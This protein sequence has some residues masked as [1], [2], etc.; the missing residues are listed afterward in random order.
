MK[1]LAALLV[2]LSAPAFSNTAK[3]IDS[4]K[5]EIIRV[6]KANMTN[7]SNLAEV[8]MELDSL[9]QQLVAISPQVTEEHI[10][11]YSPGSWQQI[12][13]DETN[14]DPP[15]MPRRDLAQIYQ[16]V[17]PMGWGY[18]F[19]V[20]K[21]D[22]TRSATFALAVVASVNGNQ[23]TTEITK[24]FMRN[25]GLQIGESLAG[26]ADSIHTGSSS[27]FQERNAGRFPNGPIGARGILSIDFIDADLK[28]GTSANVYN[29]RIEL[30]V[31]ERTAT[32]R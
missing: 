21:L 5:A 27:E 3:Q 29:G 24:A 1:F 18:N 31:M 22:A 25:S 32:V 19:G 4:L 15:G 9:L 26:L 2:F 12:W 10:G 8:R 23:Q 16:V 28:I 13:S 20:R 17:S 30:F 6:A 14:M 7:E 11:M